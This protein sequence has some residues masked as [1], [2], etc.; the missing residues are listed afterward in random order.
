MVRVQAEFMQSLVNAMGEQTKE[1]TEA[2]T[3]A[4]ADIARKPFA[5]MS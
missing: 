4:V 3:K 2:Y 1:L 5:D